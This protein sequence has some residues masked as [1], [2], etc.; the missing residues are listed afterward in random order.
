MGKR[1]LQRFAESETFGN[2]FQRDCELKG[3]WNSNYFPNDNPLVLELGCG[4]GEYTVNLGRKMPEKNFIGVDIK[5]AR[6]WRGAKTAFEEQM[7]NLAFLR[8]Q[9]ETLEDYFAAGE[10]REIWT[11]FPDPQLQLSRD[12]KCLNSPRSLHQLGRAT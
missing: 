9:I 12:R 5:G 4:R 10:V 3:R 7:E 2:V 1:K 11:T 8:L 6:L